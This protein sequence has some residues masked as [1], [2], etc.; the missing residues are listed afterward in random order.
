MPVLKSYQPWCGNKDGQICK[1]LAKNKSTLASEWKQ[2]QCLVGWRDFVKPGGNSGRS[3]CCLEL[4]GVRRW[5]QALPRGAQWQAC[6]G[7]SDTLQ[8][9][10]LAWYRDKTITAGGDAAWGP[11]VQ[12]NWRVSMLG[13]RPALLD[14]TSVWAT[15]Y[16]FEGI[17]AGSGMLRE[18]SS[19]PQIF[20]WF[21]VA[22]YVISSW[23]DCGKSLQSVSLCFLTSILEVVFYLH[24]AYVL[25]FY[26]LLFIPDY[27]W[28][29]SNNKEN[30]SL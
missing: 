15:H 26:S 7:I 14:W 23:N 3:A 8:W 13:S 1:S 9:E 5:S 25:H 10:T 22:T 12:G 6:S 24:E 18:I 11:I 28:R 29:Y 17:P 27:A 30:A 19:I 16:A 4:E 20:L 21:Q 2:F